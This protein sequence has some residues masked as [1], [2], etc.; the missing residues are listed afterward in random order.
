MAE[1]AGHN[2]A[3]ATY[4]GSS[5]TDCFSTEL[6]SPIVEE[7][8]V[9]PP[10][11]VTKLVGE[12]FAEPATVDNADTTDDYHEFLTTEPTGCCEP[13]H[14]QIRRIRMTGNKMNAS[15]DSR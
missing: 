5:P 10:K 4:Q 15:F 11:S 3:W 1:S 2:S 13:Q 9:Q 12:R 14:K 7:T 8:E 6:P